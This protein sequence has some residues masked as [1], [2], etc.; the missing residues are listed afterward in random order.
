MPIYTHLHIKEQANALLDELNIRRPVVD[1]RAICQELGIDI[2]EVSA[3][4]WFYGALTRCEDDYYI[5]L[6]KIHPETS[7]RFAIAHELGHFLLHIDDMDYQ[8]RP[9]KEYHHREADIFAMELCMPAR[10]V[11]REAAS[12]FNDHKV[13]ADIFGVSE[14]LM[15]KK[16]EELDLIPKGRFNWVYADC[17][18]V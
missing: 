13:L 4:L 11:K 6:N 3:D 12:W 16:L 18:A 14:P 8:R 17:K 1:V 5:A 9:D 15:V 7:K 2:V 10:F